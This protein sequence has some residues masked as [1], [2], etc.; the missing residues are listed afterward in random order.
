MN[1]LLSRVPASRPD[2][3]GLSLCTGS[4]FQSS[5]I[6]FQVF[7]IYFKNCENLDERGKKTSENAMKTGKNRFKIS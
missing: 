4:S 1:G 2:I 7:N 6:W 3:E 5:N